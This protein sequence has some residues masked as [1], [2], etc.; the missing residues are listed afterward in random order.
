[1]AKEKDGLKKYKLIY[2]GELL[3][4]SLVFL[5]LGILKLTGVMTSKQPRMAIF[6]WI[7]M[8]GGLWIIADFFWTLLSKKRRRKNSLLDKILNLP[9][10]LFLSPFDLYFLI[11]YP[12]PEVFSICVGSVFLYV[13]LN[14][15][16]QGIYH[17]FKPSPAL[18]IAYEEDKKMK[19]L[20][21]EE[22]RKKVEEQEKK[23][24][25]NQESDKG[26]E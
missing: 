18:L 16:F 19:E 24:A 7:T 2:S 13:F 8:I 15:A 25:Q 11:K 3:L 23:E 1:M 20:E 4:I 9:I 5:V 17:Y 14:Y 22:A 10:P 6:N 21:L 12:G 26:E